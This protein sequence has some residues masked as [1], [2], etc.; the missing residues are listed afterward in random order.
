MISWHTRHYNKNPY[1]IVLG[2]GFLFVALLNLIHLFNYEELVFK[3]RFVAQWIGMQYFMAFVL[4]VSLYFSKIENLKY[5]YLFLFYGVI[6]C[7]LLLSIYYWDIFP[8]C[9]DY[10]QGKLTDFKVISEYVICA[11]LLG[12]VAQLVFQ[13]NETDKNIFYN[14][15]FGTVFLVLSGLSFTLYSE[16]TEIFNAV[17]HILRMGTFFLFYRSF[18]NTALQK[19][20]AIIFKELHEKQGLL[21]EANRNLEKN[22]EE[23]TLLLKKTNKHLEE[24]IINHSKA[25]NRFT[26]L[27][28]TYAQ[29]III[30]NATGKVVMSNPTADKMFASESGLTGETIETLLP[31]HLE[32]A[33]KNLRKEYFKNP[34]KREMGI[35]MELV[36]KR[37]DGT[38]FP[39]EI[40]L[41]HWRDNDEMLVTAI[42]NDISERKKSENT[43]RKNNFDLQKKNNELDNF[44]YSIS[45]YI[46]A[47][48]ASLSG[49]LSIYKLEIEEAPT[50]NFYERMNETVL[51][52]DNYIKDIVN[53][54]EI[55]KDNLFP[56]KIDIS[57]LIN[58]ILLDYINT[59]IDEKGNTIT[60]SYK[61]TGNYD[62]FSD[63]SRLNI[64]MG[65]IID[66]AFQYRSPDTNEPK[67]EITVNKQS[68]R[69]LIIV[70]DNGQ[71]IESSIID[72]VFNMYFRGH[73]LSRG[74]GLGLYIVKEAV[75]ML[76]GSI[77][78]QSK[79]M[80]G[81]TVTLTLPSLEPK[82]L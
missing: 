72:K 35:G 23:R 20:Y 48:I 80:E 11:L 17:G 46:R 51:K 40:S 36:G 14:F 43:L 18:I 28:E 21:E 49:L 59:P 2:I 27:F 77:E 22:I 33:H 30:S 63:L 4:L 42:I 1:F 6:V 52:L 55:E 24:E 7:V 82:N 58:N 15:F 34:V 66:N 44:I 13:R 57:L 32:K 37:Q 45:H 60:T 73:Y 31:G 25:E 75:D 26:N 79:E 5:G 38:I 64:I 70:H 74:S 81:T 10:T 54:A 3:G 9:Y 47:P 53:F 69:I 76:G 8:V 65:Q 67:I 56:D 12:V 62:F 68:D 78:I 61:I 29:A 16:T 41:T 71:G 19:P 50:N 39:V